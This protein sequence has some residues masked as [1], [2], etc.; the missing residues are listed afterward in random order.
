MRIRKAW[1][2][3]EWDGERRARFSAKQEEQNLKTPINRELGIM[4]YKND[5]L[6]SFKKAEAN[7]RAGAYGETF[8]KISQSVV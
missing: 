2:L 4:A 1:T 8:Q 6:T 3:G 7:R 5:T